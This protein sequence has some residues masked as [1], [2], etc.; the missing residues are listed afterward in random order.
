MLERTS[1]DLLCKYEQKDFKKFLSDS[2]RFAMRFHMQAL[3]LLHGDLKS[4]SE[5][6]FFAEYVWVVMVSGFSP[7]VIYMYFPRIGKT[8]SGFN[9][10]KVCRSA[11]TRGTRYLNAPQKWSAIV[12]CARIIQRRGWKQFRIDYL[13]SVDT[14]KKLPRIGQASAEILASRIS[15]DYSPG[16]HVDAVCSY[17]NVTRDDL[18]S[19]FHTLFGLN[20]AQSDYVLWCYL[21]HCGIVGECCRLEGKYGNKNTDKNTRS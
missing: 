18:F 1:T 2:A 13:Q 19:S 8:L 16:C 7:Q 11:I 17:F 20:K 6:D 21:G 15:M 9:P 5:T 14:L 4:I 12:D 3:R 10:Y